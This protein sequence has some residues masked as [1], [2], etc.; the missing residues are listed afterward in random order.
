MTDRAPLVLLG[1]S[2]FVGA[3]LV[4]GLQHRGHVL[5]VADLAPSTVA[6]HTWVRADVRDAESVSAALDGAETLFLLAAEHGMEPRP[7]HRYEETNVGGARAVVT[8][9]RRTGLR[10]IVFT[11]TVAVYGLGRGVVTEESPTAPASAYGRTKLAAEALLRAWADEDGARSLVI[12]RPTVVF[13][14]G[15]RHGNSALF[16][17]LAQPGFRM[18]G[19]GR[20]RKSFAHVENVAAF[21]AHT[22]SLG[23][24]VHLF[25]YADG[26]DLTMAELAAVVRKAVGVGPALPSRPR[27]RALSRA[28][29]QQALVPFGGPR[30]DLTVQQLRRFCADSRFISVRTAGTGF[31][32]PL[33][34]ADA[35]E[36]FARSDLRWT[37]G[38]PAVGAVHSRA[39]RG[40]AV[41]S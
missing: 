41:A 3:A 39:I 2:G 17:L 18:V 25:N 14:S 30:P 31:S 20:A 1:G 27:W 7:A 10:R 22:A 15:G 9:A 16:H 6:P 19:D 13:G 5:R 8:A 4:R 33:S 40:D 26:P 35:L 29:L 21:L 11:S 36:R 32:A 24:G 12:V 28:A 23:S 34:L 38:H 37:A